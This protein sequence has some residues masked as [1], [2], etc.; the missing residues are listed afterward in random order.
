MMK[1]SYIAA[2]LIAL[3]LSFIYDKQLLILITSH[4]TGTLTAIFKLLST[5]GTFL[6]IPLLILS[7]VISLKK[8]NKKLAQIWASPILAV[9]ATYAIK[10]LVQ[11]SRPSF[12]QPL[13][14]DTSPS[15]PSAHASTTMSPTTALSGAIKLAWLAFAILVAY[16]RL[17]LGVHYPSDVI[18]GAMIGY[19]TGHLAGKIPFSRIKLLRR[20]KVA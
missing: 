7:I 8:Q 13:E 4:R 17:Y 9:V 15:F 16:S 2:A 6:P 11:R 19:L 3:V 10:Y 18:G 20:L 12:V 14:T 1:K 5:A